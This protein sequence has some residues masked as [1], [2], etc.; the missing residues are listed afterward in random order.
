MPKGLKS[1]ALLEWPPKPSDA[2]IQRHD[3]LQK[4]EEMMVTRKIWN[5]Q[6]GDLGPIH[7]GSFF[8]AARW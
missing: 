6:A 3:E 1:T 4:T 2:N 7:G 5:R 8:S